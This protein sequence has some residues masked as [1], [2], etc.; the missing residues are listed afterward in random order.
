MIFGVI[1]LNKILINENYKYLGRCVVLKTSLI[2]KEV[3]DIKRLALITSI[4]NLIG[5]Q[6]SSLP[7]NT[8]TMSHANSNMH[9]SVYRGWCIL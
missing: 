5:M 1:I 6:T 2:L 3:E 7:I 4:V 9:S 8:W